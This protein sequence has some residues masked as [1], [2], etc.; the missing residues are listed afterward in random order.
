M[1]LGDW[2]LEHAAIMRGA[3]RSMHRIHV[4][5]LAVVWDVLAAVPWLSG[6]LKV[7]QDALF[8]TFLWLTKLL[9]DRRALALISI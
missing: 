8:C 4:L 9:V 7:A 2:K 1:G 5:M 3:A 6:L